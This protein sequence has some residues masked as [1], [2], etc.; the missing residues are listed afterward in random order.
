M[1]TLV[2]ICGLTR[3]SDATLAVRLGANWIGC[4]L[5]PGTKRAVSA[6]QARG[7]FEAAGD[8]VRHVAVFR[9]ATPT[10]IVDQASIAGTSYVQIHGWDPKT[11]QEVQRQGLSV[12]RVHSVAE[13]ARALPPIEPPA[14]NDH[15]ILID[16]GAGGTGRAFP[17][18]L[19][20]ARAPEY[21]MIAGGISDQNV[22]RL[23]ALMPYGI[24]VSSGVE[25]SPGIKDP[26][27]LESFFAK[28][29]LFDGETIGV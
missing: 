10:Q 20:G 9:H 11:V 2:K 14:S 29:A 17:W 21:A 6:E 12:I 26:A 24:D 23:L 1:K 7:I 25:A 3:V 28:V 4:I 8:S 22:S 27:R 15:P 19:L 16:T 5:V 13:D 18:D